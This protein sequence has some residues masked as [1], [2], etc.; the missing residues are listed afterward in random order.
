MS[1][2]DYIEMVKKGIQH[3]QRGDVF[4][5]VLS[6]RF[7][8]KYKGDDF[9]VYRALRSI[10]PSPYLFYFDFGGFR[11]FGSSP[12]AQLVVKKG[13]ATIYPIAGTFRRTGNDEKDA[14]LARELFDDPKENSEHIML[15]DLARNDLSRNAENVE[16]STFKEIQYFSH[17]QK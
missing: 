17:V 6:R 3:C 14:V 12:E 9:N 7:S 13:E 8:Q 4:Q 2:E 16:V 1:D 15:V 5:I 10:N 11:I